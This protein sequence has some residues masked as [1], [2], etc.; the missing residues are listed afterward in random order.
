MILK[1]T[2]GF[3]IYRGTRANG[4]THK[5]V[6][7]PLLFFWLKQFVVC[8]YVCVSLIYSSVYA[9]CVYVCISY[10]YVCMLCMYVCSFVDTIV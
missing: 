10:V 7:S 1:D 2:V 8:M 9:Y 4:L 5:V 6:F 3:L